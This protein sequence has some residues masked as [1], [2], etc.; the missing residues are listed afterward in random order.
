[1]HTRGRVHWLVLATAIVAGV[2]IVIR[3][4]LLD[5]IPSYASTEFIAHIGAVAATLRT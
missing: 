3:P 4:V 2:S 1:M 5:R